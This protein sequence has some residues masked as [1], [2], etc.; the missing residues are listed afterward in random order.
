M[1]DNKKLKEAEARAKQYI[2][3]GAIRT[4]GRKAFVGFFTK[5]AAESLDVAN[6]LYTLSTDR[7]CTN[8][9]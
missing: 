2:K 4:N 7:L 6:A 3:S 8:S 9:Q 1:I 5:N